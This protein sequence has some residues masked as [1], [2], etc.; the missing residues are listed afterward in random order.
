MILHLKIVSLPGGWGWFS[1]FSQSLLP[2]PPPHPVCF[3]A[4][5]VR[6]Q[7]QT[8]FI[9][10]ISNQNSSTFDPSFSLHWLVNSPKKYFVAKKRSSCGH[11]EAVKSPTNN[12]PINQST[13]QAR[14]TK[15]EMVLVD[16][17]WK[18]NCTEI[19]SSVVWIRLPCPD[20]CRNSRRQRPL[21]AAGKGVAGKGVAG[22][23]PATGATTTGPGTPRTCSGRMWRI[24]AAA[25]DSAA[26][27]LRPHRSRSRSPDR[28]R[29]ETFLVACR[30]R[31]RRCCCHSGHCSPNSTTPHAEFPNP[32]PP[33]LLLHVKC[34]PPPLA[35][36]TRFPRWSGHAPPRPAVSHSICCDWSS[37]R[38]RPK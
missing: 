32:C 16:F 37:S 15:K 24:A 21:S 31:G 23:G 18:K 8:H 20:K 6:S 29:S 12:Q 25:V 33:L 38:Q 28:N 1:P 7:P 26:F 34:D 22:T 3:C 5:L 4:I 36:T 9:P 19:V 17:L 2:V 11:R 10:F 13:K 27:S 30:C 35:I 14:Q